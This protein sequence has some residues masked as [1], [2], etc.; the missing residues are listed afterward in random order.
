[1]ANPGS[2]SLNRSLE[3]IFSGQGLA[4]LPPNR[5]PE[6]SSIVRWDEVIV[7]RTRVESLEKKLDE[8]LKVLAERLR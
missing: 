2:G 7:L 4:S 3:A 5:E 1:M 6:G 8:V